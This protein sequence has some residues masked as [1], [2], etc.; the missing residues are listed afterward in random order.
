MSKREEFWS[1]LSDYQQKETAEKQKTDSW[2]CA[3]YG[4]DAAVLI[5]D[6]SGCMAYSEHHGIVHYLSMIKRMQTMVTE[7]I[8]NYNGQIVKFFATN[9]IAI[10]TQPVDAFNFFV[11]LNQQCEAG[12]TE[13]EFAI[14][15]SCGI[16][17]GRILMP[18]KQD[19]FGQAVNRASKL[20]ED[21][22]EVGQILFTA[23]VAKMLPDNMSAR[24]SNI[25]ISNI[26]MEFYVVDY[27]DYKVN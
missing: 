4:V 26:K 15:L 9:C 6:M 1:A 18:S 11:A 13:D 12:N 5:V 14:Y 21:I 16:A 17:F 2:L 10:F 20:S 25:D 22:A 24:Q 3:N 23:E 27:S 19:C 8:P 7:A